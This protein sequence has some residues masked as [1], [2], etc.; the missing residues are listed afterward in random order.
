MFFVGGK[1]SMAVAEAF[2]LFGREENDC[3]FLGTYMRIDNYAK[4]DY[5]LLQDNS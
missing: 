3:V 4:D 1:R 2:T 5:G